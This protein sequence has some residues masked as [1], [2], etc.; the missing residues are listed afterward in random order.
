MS[1]D[2]SKKDIPSIL[3]ENSRDLVKRPQDVR[4]VDVEVNF[5]R[6]FEDYLTEYFR[7]ADSTLVAHGGTLDLTFEE[8]EMYIRTL[9]ASRVAYI[10][11]DRYPIHATSRVVVPTVVSFALGSLGIVKVDTYGLVLIPKLSDPGELMDEASMRRVSNKLEVLAHFGFVFATQAYDRDKRGALDLMIMQYL[12]DQ[13]KGPGVYSHTLDGHPAF[14]LI[15]YFF[16]L[17]QL[18]SLLGARI[19]YG[20]EL[21]LRSH[22]RGLV[23]A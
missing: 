10:R 19:I 15:A 7:H 4:E 5:G 16:E 14:A 23:V 9:V 1:N 20:D 2:K 21:T 3:V 18:Q 6:A 12:T 22:L 13:P 17:K 8:F 11:G